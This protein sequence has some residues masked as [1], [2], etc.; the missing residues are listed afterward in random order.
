MSWLPR[1]QVCLRSPFTG[2]VTRASRLRRHSHGDDEHA[3]SV[4]PGDGKTG[5]YPVRHRVQVRPREGRQLRTLLRP[6]RVAGST[7]LGARFDLRRIVTAHDREP[8]GLR[9]A[10]P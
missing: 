10:E 9:L 8:L 5:T 2:W 3:G 6:R 7:R 1:E 4:D